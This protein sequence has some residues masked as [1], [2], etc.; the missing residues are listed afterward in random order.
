MK[1]SKIYIS[2]Y[3]ATTYLESLYFNFPTI[4]FWNEEHWKVKSETQEYL[5]LL[6]SV[7][8]FH[9]NPHSAAKKLEEIWDDIPNWWSSKDVQN[10]RN[11]FCNKFAQSVENPSD[12][13]KAI[14]LDKKTS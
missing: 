11:L 14:L 13:L 3:N 4:I 9:R 2:T 12:H 6:E 7:G 10:A 1:N 8:I 5:N